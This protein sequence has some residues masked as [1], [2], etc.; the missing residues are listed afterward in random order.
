MVFLQSNGVGTG[1]AVRIYKT[2][3]DQAVELV[4]AIPIAWPPMFGVSASR[5]PTSWPG[6]S[7]S[8]ALRRCG[9]G[10]PALTSCKRPARR[11]TSATRGGDRHRADGG[12][13]EH[14]GGDCPARGRTRTAGRRR[15]ARTGRRRAVAVSETAV[16]GRTRRGALHPR[17]CARA[18]SAAGDRHRG[19]TGLGREE[20]GA[21]TGGD[22]ARRHPR[23][24]RAKK[25][26]SSPAVPAS[27]RRTIVRGILEIFAAA[28]RRCRP[29]RPD[30]PRRQ[31]A[32]RDDRPR[33][34]RPF[35]ACS[36]SIRPSAASSATRDQPLDLDLLVVD[37]AS[38]VDVVL[39]NQ[40]LRR[41]RRIAC[42]VLVGDVDQLPS[43]GPGMVLADL[44]ASKTVPVV[45]L[46]EIFRQAGQ[47]W[48]V[49]AAHAI[50][51]GEQPESAPAG[52]GRFLFRRGRRR[53]KP[54]SSESS[55]WCA[56]ASRRASASIRSATCRC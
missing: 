29:V 33:S 23:R 6:G 26:W 13:D 44:I 56:N 47:S 24:R 43:V 20:D 7:A 32:E 14:S 25:C 4:R 11:A 41:C 21:A 12:T 39:M 53:R 48:I 19:G 42:V 40:L 36:N 2:Y 28:G 5:P 37:E 55:P 30:G 38:M 46:T 15:G 10:R 8:I 16:H 35:I 31:A 49:R 3:G 18:P 27:A 34:A 50:K 45:R 52:T 17:S 51:Q 1:R 22:A 9:P 54:S